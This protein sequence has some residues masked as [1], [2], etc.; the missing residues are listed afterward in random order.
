M[1]PVGHQQ[2]AGTVPGAVVLEILFYP[3]ADEIGW[4]GLGNGTVQFDGRRELLPTSILVSDFVF[5]TMFYSA[6]NSSGLSSVSGFTLLLAE[7]L[8]SGLVCP[9]LPPV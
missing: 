6:A 7:V 4:F 1:S 8:A 3:E 5:G 9:W 2:G